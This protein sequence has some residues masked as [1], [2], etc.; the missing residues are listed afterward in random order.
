MRGCFC[1]TFS[2]DLKWFVNTNLFQSHTVACDCIQCSAFNILLTVIVYRYVFYL[3]MFFTILKKK[4]SFTYNNSSFKGFFFWDILC[5]FLT[6]REMTGNEWRDGK[7]KPG[8][9]QFQLHWNCLGS[10]ST[11]LVKGSGQIQKIKSQIN[12]SNSTH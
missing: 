7:C 12:S 6:A 8:M 9:F 4:H 5:H 1:F 2:N 11:V 3:Y 10:G